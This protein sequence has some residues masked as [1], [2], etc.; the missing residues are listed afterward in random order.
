MEKWATSKCGL[1]FK[2]SLYLWPE[3]K[4]AHNMSLPFYGKFNPAIKNRKCA[5]KVPKKK[6]KTYFFSFEM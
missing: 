6:L 5:I 2:N 4:L 3:P 1:T